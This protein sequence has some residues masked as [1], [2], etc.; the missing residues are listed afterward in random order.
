MTPSPDGFAIENSILGRS[1]TSDG[2]GGFVSD[3]YALKGAV[4]EA[5]GRVRL[6]V[7]ELE[8]ETDEIDQL[9]LAAVVVPQGAEI[10]E[11]GAGHPVVFAQTVTTLEARRWSGRGS[12]FISPVAPGQ[13]YRG[14]AGDSLEFQTDPSD[15]TAGSRDRR[16]GINLIHATNVT[17]NNASASSFNCR[18]I[19]NR[20]SRDRG[21]LTGRANVVSVI[22]N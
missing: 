2:K 14:E 15:G 13:A 21:V 17:V 19:V 12:P 11:D 5:G 22:S 1:E 7:A 9:Q 18:I 10:G 8:T 3:A 4:R 16:I 20:C 6:R